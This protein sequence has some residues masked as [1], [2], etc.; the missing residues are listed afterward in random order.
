MIRKLTTTTKPTCQMCVHFIE[1]YYVT[2][3]CETIGR[4]S[5]LSVFIKQNEPIRCK[6]LIFKHYHSVDFFDIHDEKKIM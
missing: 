1:D 4:C 3:N 6:G 2:K 5:E